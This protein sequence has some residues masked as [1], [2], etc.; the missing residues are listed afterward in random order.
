MFAD[1]WGFFLGGAN[2]L[3]RIDNPG[4]WEDLLFTFSRD[5]ITGTVREEMS[6]TLQFR[7]NGAERLRKRITGVRSV[8]PLILEVRKWDSF[9]NRWEV[10]YRGTIDDGSIKQHATYVEATCKPVGVAEAL[11]DNADKEYTVQL[12]GKRVEVPRVWAA[13]PL[14][15]INKPGSYGRQSKIEYSTRSD[16]I[17]QFSA[18]Y[19]NPTTSDS[20]GKIEYSATRD[21]GIEISQPFW[22]QSVLSPTNLIIAKS[23]RYKVTNNSSYRVELWYKIGSASAPLVK[24]E[25]ISFYPYGTLQI[26]PSGIITGAGCKVSVGESEVPQGAAFEGILTQG[27]TVRLYIDANSLVDGF[28][29]NGTGRVTRVIYDPEIRVYFAGSVEITPIQDIKAVPPLTAPAVRDIDLFAQ[30]CRQVTHRSDLFFD[31]EKYIPAYWE[32]P[33]RSD[34]A[35]FLLCLSRL[36]ES[37]VAEDGT[38]TPQGTDEAYYKGLTLNMFYKYFLAQGYK[39]GVEDR[40][41]R[42]KVQ[43]VVFVAPYCNSQRGSYFYPRYDPEDTP[44]IADL[45]DAVTDVELSRYE[46]TFVRVVAGSEPEDFGAYPREEGYQDP[47]NRRIS[48]GIGAEDTGDPY[49]IAVPFPL[50]TLGLEEELQKFESESDEARQQ[51]WTEGEGIHLVCGTADDYGQIAKITQYPA[52]PGLFYKPLNLGFRPESLIRR[53]IPLLC[54]SLA[55]FDMEDTFYEVEELEGDDINVTPSGIATGDMWMQDFE[56]TSPVK[57]TYQDPHPDP[58]YEAGVRGIVR[59]VMITMRSSTTRN[60]YEA[61]ADNAT[62]YGVVKFRYKGREVA[63]YLRAADINPTELAVQKWELLPVWPQDMDFLSK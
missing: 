30:L 9:G 19:E 43:P 17:F 38:V 25:G 27:D 58:G 4:K 39:V 46:R 61:I 60:I 7:G 31:F 10:Y 41:E 16:L 59:P 48:Y 29:I 13:S 47:C 21:N 22:S 33:D 20:V 5:H 2:S 11:I 49:E 53:N 26:T 32:N 42:G 50:T 44:V 14:Y 35:C 45:G 52:L 36:K 34:A 55:P 28:Q 51:R 15:V 24:A 56:T 18:G 3:N 40:L 57:E 37:L 8:V 62:R 6:Y 54:M 12:T 23:G 63:G 1:K